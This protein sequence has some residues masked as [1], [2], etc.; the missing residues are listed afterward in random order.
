MSMSRKHYQEIAHAI[1]QVPA[2]DQH[3]WETLGR[4]LAPVLEADNASFDRQL[5]LDAC[6][7]EETSER[8]LRFAPHP[9]DIAAAVSDEQCWV[10]A[11]R[12]AWVDGYVW[13]RLTPVAG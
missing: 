10:F 9:N 2:G 8:M 6:Q 5:F 7:P 13:I 12:D 1:S 3:P 11:R 4:L